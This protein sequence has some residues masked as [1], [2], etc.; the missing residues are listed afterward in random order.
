MV[1][2]PKRP[3]KF[4]FKNRFTFSEIFDLLLI[5]NATFLRYNYFC[6]FYGLR[7]P[8]KMHSYRD[9]LCTITKTILF[10]RFQIYITLYHFK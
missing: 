9:T 10:Y 7:D 5:K 1:S 8:C 6:I 3:K 2:L 4:H